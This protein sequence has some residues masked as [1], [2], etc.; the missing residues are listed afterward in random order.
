MRGRSHAGSRAS[1]E[2]VDQPAVE[3]FH[4]AMDELA[5]RRPSAP[6]VSPLRFWCFQPLRTACHPPPWCVTCWSVTTAQS[7]TWPSS[8][9]RQAGAIKL[10]PGM[11]GRPG[12]AVEP[13]S[14]RSYRPGVVVESWSPSRGRRAVAVA[15]WPWPSTGLGELWPSTVV[16]E[17]KQPSRGVVE[18]WSRSAVAV[19]PCHRVVA[20]EPWPR[21]RGNGAMAA[22][23]WLPSRGCRAETMVEWPLS[24]LHGSEVAVP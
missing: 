15:A 22:I 6:F 13:W 23:P 1:Q 12:V 21:S 20:V 9:G 2:V 16:V 7:W 14:W 11:R 8:R 18:P 4:S 24:R 3:I 5:V 19:K 17:A 10:W